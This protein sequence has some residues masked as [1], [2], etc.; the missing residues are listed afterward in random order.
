AVHHDHSYLAVWVLEGGG[1]EPVTVGGGGNALGAG[2]DKFREVSDVVVRV[3][4]QQLAGLGIGDDGR[5]AEVAD[6]V[7]AACFVEQH[8][9]IGPAHGASVEVVNHGVAVALAQLP[10]VHPVEAK[11]LHARLCQHQVGVGV[12]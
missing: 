2:P 3:G 7:G 11:L 12:G 8:V 5:E 4:I 1:L 10:V 6:V 9:P